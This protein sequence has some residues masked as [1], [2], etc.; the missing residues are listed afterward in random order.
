MEVKILTEETFMADMVNHPSHYNQGKREV[1]EEM[2][3][4]FGDI[5]VKYF[6]NLSAYKYIRR[7]DY[8]GNKEQDLAKAEW[9][10]D[11]VAKMND[12]HVIK[13]NE[14]TLESTEDN[15]AQIP[16][17]ADAMF[18]VV[19]YCALNDAIEDG[20]IPNDPENKDY[21]EFEEDAKR[22]YKA[23]RELYYKR[24][25]NGGNNYGKLFCTK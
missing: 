21:I 9:Y 3:L 10:M 19:A 13:Y 25:I 4:L 24:H 17:D 6:C 15:S 1:I 18:K 20:V 22:R 23:M 16:E 14:C 11:Y 7:A 12:E 5:A 8:K 2:R